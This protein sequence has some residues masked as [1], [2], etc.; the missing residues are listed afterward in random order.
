MEDNGSAYHTQ[1]VRVPSDSVMSVGSAKIEGA[2]RIGE[3][4]DEVKEL[5]EKANNACL[6]IL[7]HAL[8]LCLIPADCEKRK[9][10]Q[11]TRTRSECWK[12]SFGKNN[13][14]TRYQI[15]RAPQV[16]L[17]PYNGQVYLALEVSWVHAR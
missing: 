14:S 6:F 7:I 9:S 13:G 15:S 3:L 8:M 12:R 2:E 1:I 4:E 5:A 11:T 16:R 17:Q 10:M